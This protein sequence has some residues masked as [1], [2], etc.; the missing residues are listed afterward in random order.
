MGCKEGSSARCSGV[1][2]ARPRGWHLLRPR[3]TA[4]AYPTERLLLTSYPTAR[5]GNCSPDRAERD[6][7][8]DGAL[9]YLLEYRPPAGAVWSHGVRRSAFPPRPAH[10]ALRRR[11]LGNYECWRVAS[12]L[13]RFRAADRPFQLHVALGPQA[14]PAL[15]AQ[16][17]RALD[18]LRFATLPPPPA[19]RRVTATNLERA[20]RTNPHQPATAA[21]RAPTATDRR[22]AARVFGHT[23]RL[24]VCR[25]AMRGRRPATFDVQVLANGCFVAERRRR[26]Q[27]DYGCVR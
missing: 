21:C 4:L 15:R 23:T 18:S 2:I 1:G 6:L 19:A 12:Y 17:L 13:I 26:G 10:F 27:A 9:I 16:V 3:I 14:S 25:I 22:R 7:P 11:E 8:A 5:G 20:L 24:F